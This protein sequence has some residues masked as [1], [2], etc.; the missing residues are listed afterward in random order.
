MTAHARQDTTLEEIFELLNRDGLEA[1]GRAFVLLLNQAMVL[2]RQH[3]L[4]LE[5]Y[6]RNPDRRHDWA[7]GFKDKTLQTRLGQ[8]TVQIPQVRQGAFYP[9]ALDKGLRSERALKLALAEMYVQG[10]STRKVAQI[11]E[12][13]CGFAVSSSQ[14]SRASAELDTLLSQWREREL[15]SY[16]YLF[17]DARYENV[18]QGGL[19][20]DCAVLLASGVGLDGK[21]EVLGVSVS[22]SEAEVHWRGFLQSL[23]RRGLH[24]VRL[25]V[26]DDHAGLKAARRAVFPEV[27]WQRC[28]FHL[29]RNAQ[30]Y[31]P[32]QAIKPEVAR[33]LRRVF[34]ASDLAEAQDRLA[35]LVA[36]YQQ[37]A[38]KLSQW[39]ETDVIESLT[40]FGYPESHRRRLRTTNMQER[41]NREIRRRTRVVSQFPNDSSCLR[42]VTAVI[43]ELSEEWQA[44]RVYLN[45]DLLLTEERKG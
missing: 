10:V 40:V 7:N 6:E 41:L 8:L 25:V 1:L 29:Q 44:G 32:R 3:Y 19:V 20:R 14:V 28:Q 11:T 26:S 31:V 37:T 45:M 9:S 5:P 13:L 24:G 23:Q 4:G 18:R 21:R 39:I 43:M 35:A 16:P 42:L 34:N 17:L 30:A 33:D 15:G 2:E 12:Q 38:P 27:P 22:M 36:K